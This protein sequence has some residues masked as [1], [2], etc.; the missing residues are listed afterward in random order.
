MPKSDNIDKGEL[1]LLGYLHANASGYGPG[2]NFGSKAVMEAL[3]ID[4]LKFDR[5]ATFLESFN[6]IGIESVV[7]EPSTPDEPSRIIMSIYLTGHGEDYMRAI[8]K[9]P[10]VGRKLTDRIISEL[11]DAGKGPTVLAVAKLLLAELG[12]RL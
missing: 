1:R 11:W 7:A 3:N 4:D 8:E 9:E 6:L 5:Q 12:H 2:Y 10:S